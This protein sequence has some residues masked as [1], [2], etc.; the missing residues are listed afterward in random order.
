MGYLVKNRLEKKKKAVTDQKS[1]EWS[2]FSIWMEKLD[3]DPE[4]GDRFSVEE[5]LAGSVTLLHE[6]GCAEG[7]NW[8]QP[9][10][11][12]LWNFNLHYLEFL[13]PLAATYRKTGDRRCYE[14][15][16]SYCLQWIEDNQDGT[17][18]GWH[19]YTISLRLTNLWICMDGFGSLFQQDPELSEKLCGS[20]YAQYQ[21]LQKRLERHLLGNHYL[22][23]LKAVLLG[24]L[25]FQEEQ[26]YQTY[27]RLFLKELQEQVLPDGM[28]YERSPMYHKIVLEDVMR[29]AKAAGSYDPSLREQLVKVMGKMADVMFSLEEGMGQTPLFND[30]GNNVARPFDSLLAALKEEFKI[31]PNK[32]QKFPDAGYF[33]G[34]KGAV[35]VVLDAGVIAPDYMPGHGHCDGLS[36]ELSF[37]GRPLFVN[38]G[39][40]MYQGALRSWFRSTR[41]HNTVM[42]DGEEQSQCWGEHRVAGRIREV[43]GDADGDLLTGSLI[44]ASGKRQARSIRLADSKTEITDWIR[45]QAEAFLHLASEYSYEL[46]EQAVLVKQQDGMAVCRI[47]W[48]TGDTVRIL[49]QGQDCAYA[50][51]FGRIEQMQVLHISW[52]GEGNA[53][54]IQ[55]IWER[56]EDTKH[57]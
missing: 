14:S 5:I 34:N 31:I 22:E 49:T 25:F 6:S 43:S 32:R 53:H 2:S 19:P 18:D 8:S 10:K 29:L 11:S 36:F 27:R 42:I 41:A 3:Q 24:S 45:G 23:N 20:M 56:E 52:K 4:Y 26:V 40:G 17:G 33:C 51:E 30:S 9:D 16:R 37:Q 21:H 38:A 13:I 28:H 46:E 7:R 44:T 12:H 35:K 50:S 39:T 1:P 57:D 47:C 54:Q 15:F 55:M 48:E